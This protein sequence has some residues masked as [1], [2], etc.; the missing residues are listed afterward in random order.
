ME[1][2]RK[3]IRALTPLFFQEALKKEMEEMTKDMRFCQQRS[4]ERVSLNVFC[5]SLPIP[6]K[7]NTQEDTGMDFDTIDYI[8]GQEE[9][10]AFPFPWC[11]VKIDGGHIPKVND[12]Q[13]VQV[14]V[15][16]GIF[17]DS[18]ENQGH[19]EVLNLIQNVYERFS[20]NPILDGQYTCSGEFEW[21]L[22]DE[23]TYPYF[24]GAIGT[25]FWFSGF[26]REIKW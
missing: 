13:E 22:Q 18:L 8:D 16:F 9:A 11:L 12:R 17:N 7:K 14:A 2:E 10:A 21:A 15:C 20:V 24:F 6:G 4:Q 19:K 25:T 26:R 5:Q 1:E 3:G 23:D